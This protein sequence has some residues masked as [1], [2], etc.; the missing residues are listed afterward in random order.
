[1]PI[2]PLS[3]GIDLLMVRELTGKEQPAQAA[4]DKA[5]AKKVAREFETLFVGMMIKT[6]RETVGKDS[7]T[8]GGRG[9]EIY[10]S[11]LDQEYARAISESHGLGLAEKLE[12]ELLK[13]IPVQDEKS[14]DSEP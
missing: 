6:M 1:M 7:L 3:P 8:N 2:A 11:L 13:T 14:M 10:S 12:K 5:A 9:E 4:K